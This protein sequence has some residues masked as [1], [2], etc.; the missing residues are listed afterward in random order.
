MSTSPTHVPIAPSAGAWAPPLARVLLVVR[1]GQP[2]LVVEVEGGD[3]HGIHLHPGDVRGAWL[4]VLA[5]AWRQHRELEI[6]R[7][8]LE[9][10]AI[11][12]EIREAGA[13]P[14]RL[15]DLLAKE[16]R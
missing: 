3:S 6:E 1:G 8:N 14:V 12:E 4:R 15:E 11:A 13:E 10:I 5:Q 2:L 7:V 16:G 9:T